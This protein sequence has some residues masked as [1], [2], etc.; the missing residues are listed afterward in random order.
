MKFML[1]DNFEKIREFIDDYYNYTITISIT[2]NELFSNYEWLENMENWLY[3]AEDKNNNDKM[4]KIYI[5]EIKKDMIY[6]LLY[7]QKA[8]K[9]QIETDISI[10][11]NGSGEMKYIKY[12]Y[13]KWN[14][15]FDFKIN[16]EK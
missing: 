5:K 4:C 7:N 12:F 9:E 8:I 10:Y 2:E 6:D 3:N 16:F 13:N 15:L 11:G 1:N 14:R